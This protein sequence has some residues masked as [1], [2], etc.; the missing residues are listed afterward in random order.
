MTKLRE[1]RIGSIGEDGRFAMTLATEGEASDGDILSIQGAQVPERMPLLLSHWN[2]PTATAG[3]VVEPSKELKSDPARLRAVG[4]IELDGEGSLADVRRDVAHMIARGHIDAVSVRWDEVDGG[5]PPVRRVNL[6]SDHPAYVDGTDESVPWRKRYGMF[7]EDWRAMEGS[8]VAIGADPQA[9]I[10]RSEATEG[11]VSAFWREMARQTLQP[12]ATHAPPEPDDADDA[13]DAL[14]E[15]LGGEDAVRDLVPMNF[16]GATLY[17][18][19]RVATAAGAALEGDA[20]SAAGSDALPEPV[21]ADPPDITTEPQSR[22][23]FDPDQ[24]AQALVSEIARRDAVVERE[25][26]ELVSKALGRA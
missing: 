24:F 22:N 14:L 12:D 9:L 20:P 2:D 6:S 11:S 4:Q 7:W 5:K 17:V 16:E 3:S 25:L 18:P 15:L 1:A 19:S 10:G 8:I 26:A 23:S 21:E 13:Q